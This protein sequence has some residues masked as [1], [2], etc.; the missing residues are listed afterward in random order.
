MSNTDW[1][2]FAA[3][4]DRQGGPSFIETPSI[5]FTDDDTNHPV[6]PTSATS[7]IG[8]IILGIVVVAIFW[9][10]SSIV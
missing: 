5:D 9:G 2:I 1:S 6:G 8:Q 3:T 7:L 4:H 10:L